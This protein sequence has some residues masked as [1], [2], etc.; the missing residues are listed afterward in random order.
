MTGEQAKVLHG[1]VDETAD[2]LTRAFEQTAL[3]V[4]RSFDLRTARSASIGCTYPHHGT[5]D[6]DCQMVVLLIYSAPNEQPATLLLHGNGE[7]TWIILAEAPERE[8][9]ETI[10][11][12][13]EPSIQERVPLSYNC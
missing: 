1:G 6:C 5:A 11:A 4:Y 13:L 8:L 9:E 2:S 7:R 12:V 3:R 10:V